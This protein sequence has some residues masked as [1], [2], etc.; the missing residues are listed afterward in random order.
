M[1]NLH[2]VLGASGGVG[3]AVTTLLANEGQNVR[4]VNRSGAIPGLPAS[5]STMAADAL[6][7]GDMIDACAGASVVYH[8][9]HPRED[10][11]QF[12]PMLNTCMLRIR[13]EPSLYS[14]IKTVQWAQQLKY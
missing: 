7:A 10:Y 1:S 13:K 5:V 4:A 8:C 11:A 14:P 6:N 2:V 12:V 3:R 9:V